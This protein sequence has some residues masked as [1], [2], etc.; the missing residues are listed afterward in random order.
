MIT[1]GPEAP[2]P[3][4]RPS[5]PPSPVSARTADAVQTNKKKTQHIRKTAM[6]PPDRTF[7]ES[8]S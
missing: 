1:E 2:V 8:P 3:S 4:R 5:P 7:M 6:L